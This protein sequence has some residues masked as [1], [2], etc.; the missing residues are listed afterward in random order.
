MFTHQD[1]TVPNAVDLYEQVRGSG[2]NYVGFK[3]VG[4][5]VS[6]LQAVCEAAHEDGVEVMLEV[7]STTLEEELRSV[8][9]GM[10]LGA[11]WIL[12]GTHPKDVLLRLAGC[13]ARYCPFPGRVIGHPS[14]LTGEVAEIVESA[15]RIR[16]LSGVSGLDLLAYRH[17][18]VDGAVLAG[19][20]ASAV[21]G[22]VIAAGSIDR[23]EQIAALETTGV[24]GFTV[25]T[26]IMDGKLPGGPTIRGQ[27]ESVIAKVED[28]RGE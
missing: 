19:A 1:L 15:S 20:V 22:P 3:D 23:M 25:G 6:V 24:W 26:A 9:V 16:A 4:A 13:R 12:G 18:D 28:L 5:P 14:V 8:Q 27:V 17:P 11:D 10:G 2:L 7:V 21:T